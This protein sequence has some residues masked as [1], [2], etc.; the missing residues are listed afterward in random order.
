M[1]RAAQGLTRKASPA[2]QSSTSAPADAGAAWAR[3]PVQRW[4]AIMKVS[5]AVSIEELR[6][7]CRARLPRIVFD[8]IEEGA[9]DESALRRNM[10]SFLRYRFAPRYLRD[11]STRTQD[12][13]IFGSTFSSPF[14]F[15]PTGM[16]GLIRGRAEVMM[17]EAAVE[18]NLP[19]VMSGL[20]TTRM[21]TV[22]RIAP[23]HLWYQ[24][25]PSADRR[26]IEGLVGRAADCGISTLV[27]TV[28][29]PVEGKRLRSMRHR[30]GG[31]PNP[32]TYLDVF[33][34]PGWLADYLQNRPLL[35]D[36]APYAPEGAKQ[37]DLDV[38]FGDQYSAVR[39]RQTWSDLEWFRRNWKGK[40]VVKGVLSPEDALLALNHGVDGVTVSNHGGR[41][42]ERAPAPLDVLP[43]V[44]QAVAGRIPVFLDSG[45]RRGADIVMAL[46]LGASFTFIG[47]AALYGLAAGGKAGVGRTIE[48]LKS[49]IDVVMGQI[50]RLTTVDLGP[51]CL[52]PA[53]VDA[54]AGLDA[55]TSARL[56][57]EDA[58]AEPLR[59][60]RLQR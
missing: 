48:I 11:V 36:L 25:Y 43:S 54:T 29:L 17:A 20:T 19:Y 52:L 44:V 55:A 37:R 1:S 59:R 3:V 56:P 12:K 46:A 39:E 49:D 14:G 58:T 50:G 8:W 16:Q 23:N 47:R 45:I 26:I 24:P 30:R 4:K 18:A 2:I 34:H 7:L 40:L 51:D 6:Q 60:K 38:L 35:E 42:L 33:M 57:A 10:E 32:S 9:G 41:Q 13:E 28:D 53:D 15:S 22:A 21:E 5:Q 27:I 31:R